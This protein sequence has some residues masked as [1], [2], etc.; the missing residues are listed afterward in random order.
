MNWRW[1]SKNWQRVRDEADGIWWQAHVQIA[2]R[3][4]DEATAETAWAKASELLP[5]ADIIRRSVQAS[6]YRRKFENA[7][8]SL[9]KLLVNSPT[10]ER[11]LRALSYA[12]VQLGDYAQAVEYLRQLVDIDVNNPKYQ[13][14]LAQCYAKRSSIG[15]DRCLTTAVRF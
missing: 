8:G 6:L 11:D 7:V 14:W 15:R 1:R 9:K 2:E 4:G 3:M 12:L 13:I 5:H 10:S